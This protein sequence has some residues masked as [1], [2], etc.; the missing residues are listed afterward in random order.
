MKTDYTPTP[1]QPPIGYFVRHGETEL[2]AGDCYRGWLNIPLDENGQEQAQAVAQFFSY[3]AIGRIVS[4]DLDRAMQTANTVMQCGCVEC[5]YLSPDF[6]LRPWN[7]GGFSGKEKT[8]EVK[9][10]LQ[11]YIDNPDLRVPDGES[12][13]EFRQRNEVILEYFSVPFNGKPTIVV[14]HTSN[15]VALHNCLNKDE[16]QGEEAVDLVEPG[17]VVAVY[18]QPD[19]TLF[20]LPRMGEVFE[21]SPGEA[22]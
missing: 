20:L 3:E 16:N 22:S 18:Q 21:A 17:G 10:K 8:A 12:L 11:R 1:W 13:N 6:N 15:L 5:P 4:S 2:N 14:A 9:K 19:G 7:I